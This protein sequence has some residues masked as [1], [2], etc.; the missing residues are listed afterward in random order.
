MLSL[1]EKLKD[2]FVVE[3][4]SQFSFNKDFSQV[5]LSKKDNIIYIYSIPILLKTKTWKLIYKL[6]SHYEYIS[7]I[8]WNNETNK[9]LTCSYDK[10]SFVWEF[11]DNNWTPLN[12]VYPTK[13]G[14]LCCKWN[15]RGDKFCEGTSS[16]DLIIGYYNNK[17]K[18]WKGK[19]IKVHKSSVVTCEI[20]PTSFFVLSGSTDLRIYVS[21]CY[22]SEI[23]DIFLTS[24]SK[25]LIKEFGQILYE[26]KEKSLIN[27]VTWFNENLGLI[28]SHDATISVINPFE[29]KSEIIRCNHSPVTILISYDNKSFFAVCYDRNILEYEKKEN[30]WV[31]KRYI[32]LK[33]NYIEINGGKDKPKKQ[34][35]ISEYIKICR[36]G[37]GNYEKM[38]YSLIKCKKESL[39]HLCLISSINLKNNIIIT[40]DLSGFV[41]FW[42]I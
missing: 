9:I 22:I 28:A 11:I 25:S 34:F 18:R 42:K 31:I 30:I 16:K 8:D 15:K 20:D 33:E 12:S 3:G 36:F 5:A 24:S 21:S 10:T 7:G 37:S 27:S 39:L 35:N 26:F 40:S 41:K 6:E 4:I 19:S 38:E 13:L 2:L 32:T 23:D 29:Q 17:S 14:Y 1:K